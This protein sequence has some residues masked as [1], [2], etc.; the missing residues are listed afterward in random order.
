MVKAELAR[1]DSFEAGG[2]KKVW[3]PMCIKAERTRAQ[4]AAPF[5]PVAEA[6]QVVWKRT[7][8]TQPKSTAQVIH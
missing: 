3:M 8:D 4:V 1:E 2:R 5:Q 6:A 7:S